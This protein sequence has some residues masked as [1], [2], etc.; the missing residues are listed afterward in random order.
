VAAFL[1]QHAHPRAAA[2]PPTVPPVSP[3]ER[4][5]RD[6]GKGRR[7]LTQNEPGWPICPQPR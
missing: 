1:R 4:S 3:L 2:K 5:W 7:G 6:P